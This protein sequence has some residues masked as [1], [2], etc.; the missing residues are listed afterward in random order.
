M[1]AREDALSVTDI[2][3]KP[4]EYHMEKPAEYHMEKACVLI[5]RMVI[6]P[7]V[8]ANIPHHRFDDGEGIIPS[9]IEEAK[10]GRLSALVYRGERYDLGSHE[11]YRAIL[12]KITAY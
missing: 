9:L 6:T 11:G 2:V 10:I 8:M 3:E 4:A 7:R 5:G 12:R 1:H